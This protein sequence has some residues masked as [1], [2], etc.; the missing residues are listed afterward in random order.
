MLQ[1]YETGW[2]FPE[3]PQVENRSTQHI[4]QT[5]LSLLFAGHLTLFGGVQ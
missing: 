3:L 4:D 5:L 2:R 1:S